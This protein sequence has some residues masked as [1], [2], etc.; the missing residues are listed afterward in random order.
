[1]LLAVDFG[2]GIEDGWSK[3]TEFVPKFLAFLAI[4]ERAQQRKNQARA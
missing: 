4:P 3:I 2:A 1:M